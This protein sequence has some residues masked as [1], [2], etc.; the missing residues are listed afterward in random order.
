M[1]LEEMAEDVGKIVEVVKMML[2]IHNDEIMMVR[3]VV[4]MPEVMVVRDSLE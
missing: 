3:E 4:V 1:I 2:D